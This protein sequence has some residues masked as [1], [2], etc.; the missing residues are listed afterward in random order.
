VNNGEDYYDFRCVAA[1]RDGVM[2][3]SMG[4]AVFDRWVSEEEA[5]T[6]VV[7]AV[8]ST[9]TNDSFNCYRWYTR[10]W[11]ILPP[12]HPV[13]TSSLPPHHPVETSSLLTVGALTLW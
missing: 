7:P 13:E 8:C 4:S 3:E 2:H 9:V 5:A 10:P 11:S 1:C 12:Y 6:G